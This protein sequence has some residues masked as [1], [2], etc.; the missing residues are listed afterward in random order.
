MGGMP[1]QNASWPG[2]SSYSVASSTFG[3]GTNRCEL[4]LKG[5]PCPMTKDSVTELV[6]A[7]IETRVAN[8][9]A[10]D[11]AKKIKVGCSPGATF[12]TL[13]FGTDVLASA[14]YHS[15]TA[16]PLM[17][18]RTSAI[19]GN[20]SAEVKVQF[21]R[22]PR[23]RAAGKQLSGGYEVLRTVVESKGFR[24]FTLQAAKK[25]GIMTKDGK[26]AVTLLEL[27]SSNGETKFKPLPIPESIGIDS[28]ELER[29]AGKA[30]TLSRNRGLF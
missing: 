11:M 28:V 24:L 8:I 19:H 18:K 22:P 7:S 16:N 21:S 3:D 1:A 6:A 17:F 9:T 13:R 25:I 26:D 2:S 12:A 4:V 27:I 23:I 20:V 5:F 10:V 15:T 14:Y 29:L 30:N